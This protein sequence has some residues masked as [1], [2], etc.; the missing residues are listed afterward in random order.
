MPV[1]SPPSLAP[2]V[3]PS[4]FLHGKLAA[5]RQKILAVAVLTGISMAVAIGVEALALAMFLDWW[6]DLPRGVRGLMLAAQVGI[7]G[8][9]LWRMVLIPIIRQPSDDE[10]A[11]MV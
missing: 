10:L 1:L 9:I 2:S 4:R 7:V 6:L 3:S 8:F 5:L 11:L